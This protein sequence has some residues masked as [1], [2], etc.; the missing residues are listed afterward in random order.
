[1]ARVYEYQV[2]AV[3]QS[4]VTFVNGGWRGRIALDSGDTNVA[5]ESCPNVWD[6]LQDAG[7]EGWELV[8]ALAHDAQNGTY[9]MLYLKRER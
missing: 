7:Y 8:G 9:D 2:C 4:R 1:L 3:Q 6:Y 5:L